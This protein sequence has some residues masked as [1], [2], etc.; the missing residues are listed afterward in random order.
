[1][2]KKQRKRTKGN[3]G[4]YQA[5]H[6]KQTKQTQQ[7][8]LEQEEYFRPITLDAFT[9]AGQDLFTLIVDVDQIVRFHGISTIEFISKVFSTE[10]RTEQI[11]YIIEILKELQ[12]QEARKAQAHI[13]L[14]GSDV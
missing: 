13:H 4:V 12:A 5:K 3:K 8:K 9:A 7:S 1:M 10:S 2:E 11:G 6:N 14:N